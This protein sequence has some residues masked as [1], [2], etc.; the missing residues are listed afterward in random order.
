[1]KNFIKIGRFLVLGLALIPV[2]CDQSFLDLKPKG[3]TLESNFY[4]TE[5]DFYRG[6]VA[7]YDML[8]AQGG[9]GM[10][11]G[12]L[13]TA[14]DDCYAGG[15]DPSD[16]PNWVA[17]DSFTLSAT[18]GPQQTLWNHN[19]TGI[20]RANLL[21]EK[22]GQNTTLKTAY[23]NRITAEAKFLRAFFYF[24]LVRYFGKVPLI[25]KSLSANEIYQQTQ[26]TPEA[27]YAQIEQDLRDAKA[28]LELPETV[29]SAEL[30]R[31]TKQAVRAL[32]GKVLLYQNNNAK[33]SEAAT[34]FE[35]VIQSGLFSLEPNFADIFKTDHEFGRESVF[36]IVFS[37][38]S[39]GGWESFGNTEGN[40]SQQF[41][42]IRDYV[43]PTF[44]TGWSFSPVT[45]D[46]AN[47]MQGD[48]RFDATI[49]DGKK[50]K[51]QGATY[52]AGYQNTDYFIRKY[53]PTKA[54]R[55]PLGEPALNWKANIRE[56]RYADVLLMAA[57]ALV[58]SGGNTTKARGYLNQ[59]R[60]RVQL[61]DYTGSDLL[62]AI[63]QERRMELATEGHRFFDLVR[64][65]QAAQVLGKYG[66][67]SPRHMFLPIP[68]N[69]IDIT[70]NRIQQN[71]GY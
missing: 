39:A 58:R 64:T 60:S 41:F 68:Q 6:L 51:T 71:F 55:P 65:G 42:G 49:I 12:L 63:Y 66:Y 45:E 34:N 26:S 33:M 5:D 70:N 48:P 4:Q 24:D 28:T 56:I 31:V 23:K 57:E 47:A 32:L 13:N 2:S 37:E 54:D 22:L 36:E 25:T 9:W 10:R 3:Q 18:L 15:S 62:N 11:L 30:G 16:Q 50:L 59:V 67:Q 21:L 61:P 46:L 52:T 43:G 27:V 1:M 38:L 19:Y 69:E 8:Q 17:W 53:A 7:V 14:S 29:A 44:E 20:Y 40:Y 35:E